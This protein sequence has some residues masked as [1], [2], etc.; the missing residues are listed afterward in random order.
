MVLQR[1]MPVPIWQT[2]AGGEQVSVTVAS[3]TKT[4]AAP[5]VG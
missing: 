2:A 5:A 4:V 1:D 3:Q